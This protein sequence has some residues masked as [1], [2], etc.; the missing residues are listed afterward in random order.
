MYIVTKLKEKI[1]NT[2][3]IQQI[4]FKKI[5]ADDFHSNTEYAIYFDF[6]RDCYIAY[7]SSEEDAKIEIEDI[8]QALEENKKIFYLS[9]I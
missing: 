7:Y 4:I 6:L 9:N 3:K 5:E 2:D 8:I 1:L